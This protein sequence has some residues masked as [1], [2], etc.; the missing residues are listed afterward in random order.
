MT[1][2]NSV[3]KNG[4]KHIDLDKDETNYFTS[5]LTFI[6][7]PKKTLLLNEGQICKNLIYVHSGA[8]RAYCMD[9]E[10]KEAT[11]MFATA[12]VV[13]NRYVSFYK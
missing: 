9:K 10:G 1:V 11:I 5:L 6:E 7:A 3:L 8:L 13:G 4:A 12:D 2:C